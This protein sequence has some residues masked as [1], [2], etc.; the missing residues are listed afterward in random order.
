MERRSITRRSFAKAA[1]LAGAIGAVGLTQPTALAAAD[2]QKVEQAGEVKKVFTACRGCIAFCGVVAHVKDG[3]VIKIEGNKDNPLSRGA[4]C[5]KG[6]SGLQA[7][8]HPNRNKYPMKRVGERGSNEWERISWDEAIDMI[9][10]KF[11]EFYHKYGPESVMASTG[12]GG[13]P[14]FPSTHRFITA[15]GGSNSFEPGCAQCF[16]PRVAMSNLMF[17]SGE[18][19]K[20]LSFADQATPDLFFADT[21]LSALVMWGTGPSYHSPSTSGRLITNLR[22]RE[23][24]IKTV[25]IDPRMTPD[26]ARAD[27][28]L[29]IRPGTDVAL[30]LSWMH[31]IVENKLYD[32]DFCT[33]W[34]NLPFL[35]NPETGLCLKASEVGLGEDDEYVVWDKN[36]G[37]AVA[38]PFPFPD[39]L[40]VELFG[41][42]EVSGKQCPTAFELLAQRVADWTVERAAEVCWLDADKIY[43]ALDIYTRPKRISGIT[44]GVATDQYIQSHEAA[45]SALMLEMLMGHV[46]KP[47]AILQDFPASGINSDL[48]PLFSMQTEHIFEKRL[49]T[50]EHKGLNSWGMAHI[51][52]IF[53]AAI[54]GDPYRIHGWIERSGNKHAMIAG[55]DILEDVVDNI[56]FIVH[57]YMYPTA[58]SVEAADVVLPMREWLEMNKVF[59]Q[60][61]TIGC[62][63]EVVHLFETYDEA[64]AYNQIIKRCAELGNPDAQ[65]ALDGTKTAPLP[66]IIPDP[67]GDAEAR[68]GTCGLTWEQL[69]EEGIHEFMPESEYRRYYTYLIE[70]EDGKPQGFSTASKRCEPYC[71]ALITLSMTGIPFSLSAGMKPIPIAAADE[72]YDPLPN[73]VEPIE[74]PLDDAEYPL[75]L[76]QGRLPMYH[77][78]TLRN[79]PYLREI[80]PVAE[81]WV[82][83]ADAR[84][85]GVADQDWVNVSS[86]RATITA[87]AV[88]T[89]RIAKGVVYMERFWNPEFLDSDDPSRAWKVMNVNRLTR[90]EGPYNSVFGTYTL[91]GFDVKISKAEGAPE[92]VWMEPED[93]EPWMPQPSDATEGVF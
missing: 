22:N 9:A 26:A 33:K 72:P 44:H 86:R 36:A 83:P 45:Q 87:R 50:R 74:S 2:P 59:E 84:K 62:R 17:C 13:N 52:S 27:V 78:G 49:G 81:L 61:N 42:H 65:A 37:A 43:E 18:N 64:M 20:N 90:N 67:K 73:Y 68:M 1:A 51:P 48:P 40:Q 31:H 14:N 11:M 23:D 3:R 16:L 7:L 5:A 29:P 41:T 19:F 55:S 12:G 35:V 77:H 71:D 93:F 57:M 75:T 34:T 76:T 30:M 54:D 58:F 39:G 89:E 91:R 38:L 79:V 46:E 28:W 85:Y 70:D 60:A 53:K 8:Y 56:D 24:P 4:L 82:N 15:F 63:Q 80:Y 47:G 25:V 88:V 10:T 32:E 6:L 69:C 21:E 66:P 92:G